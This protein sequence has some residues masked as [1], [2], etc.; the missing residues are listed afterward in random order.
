MSEALLNI[1][2]N[3]MKVKLKL[4][5]DVPPKVYNN[6]MWLGPHFVERDA[7]EFEFSKKDEW[8][9]DCK[10]FHAY[11]EKVGRKVNDNDNRKKKVQEVTAG[12]QA[13]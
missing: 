10:Q 5:E 13:E 1:E 11:M 3:T 4:K 8:F 12:V 7:K 2:G 6:G 9:L